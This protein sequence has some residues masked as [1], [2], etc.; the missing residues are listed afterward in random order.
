M[1]RKETVNNYVQ[2]LAVNIQL[3]V[4]VTAENPGT[5]EKKVVRAI[6]EDEMGWVDTR[7]QNKWMR[8]LV[9]RKVIIPINKEVF[10]VPE[11]KQRSQK[12]LVHFDVPEVKVVKE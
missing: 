7:T 11:E 8:I 9:R 5:V 4:D 12:T 6:M 3:S 1:M 2:Q 10:Y